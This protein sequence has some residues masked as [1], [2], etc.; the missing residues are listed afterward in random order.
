M[1]TTRLVR[2]R[3]GRVVRIASHSIPTRA[4]A[5]SYQLHPDPERY[6]QMQQALADRGYYKGPINGEWNDESVDALRRFQVDKKIDDDADGKVTALSLIGLGL[7]PRH[8]AE[9]NSPAPVPISGGQGVNSLEP[10]A[11]NA[12]LPRATPP[13]D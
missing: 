13:R 10:A 11:V 1:S 9:L 8:G 4:P 12:V 7:G 2:D 5:P 6:G 3:H